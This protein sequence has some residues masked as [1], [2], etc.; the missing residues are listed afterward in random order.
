M[1]QA[2]ELGF[3]PQLAIGPWPEIALAPYCWQVIDIISSHGQSL[4][5]RPAHAQQAFGVL[6]EV[7]RDARSL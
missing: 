5:E 2:T 4:T 1:S 7:G 3:D 6:V